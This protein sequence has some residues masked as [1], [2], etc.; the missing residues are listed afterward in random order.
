[1]TMKVIYILKTKS[2]IYNFVEVSGRNLRL[3]V[4]VYIVYITNQFRTTGKSVS[5]G[6]CEQQ[7]GK[8]FRPFVPITVHVIYGRT[9]IYNNTNFRHK[10]IVHIYISQHCLRQFS[11]CKPDWKWCWPFQ[12]FESILVP[13]YLYLN[14]RQNKTDK[15]KWQ[16]R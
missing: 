14:V 9:N 1:M 15:K 4:S 11:T 13:K 7:G 5:R 8:L 16:K 10:T 3:E 2:W 6:D 12:A